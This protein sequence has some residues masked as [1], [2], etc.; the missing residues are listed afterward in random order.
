LNNLKRNKI[1][2]TMFNHTK[3]CFRKAIG[4]DKNDMKEINAKL[5]KMSRHIIMTQCK[6]SEL[7]EEIAKEFS[8]N[9]LLFIATLF[10]TEKTAMIV[11]ADANI[12]ELMQLVE[13]LK[14]LKEKGE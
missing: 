3:D 12:S 1:M 14:E 6:Q 7:C 11:R 4:F 8:Y 5:A 2:E 9:E 10:I 13:L